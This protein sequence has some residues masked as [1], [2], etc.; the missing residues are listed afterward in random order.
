[1]KKMTRY[2]LMEHLGPFIFAFFT[3]TFLLVIDHVPR[4]IDHVID[5]DISIWIALELVALNLAWMLALSVPMAVLVA[6]LMA[7]GRLTADFEITAIKASG[8]N[9]MRIMMPLLVA[10]SL[11]MVGMVQFNDTILPDLN[12]KARLLW[13]DIAAMRPTLIFRSGIFI[14]DIPGWLVLIDKIDHT[15]SR[16]EGVRITETRDRSKPQI[17]ISEYG[18]MK[19]MDDGLS[20]QFTLYNGEIHKLDTEE[21]ENYRRL[22]FEK[23]VINIA[24]TGTEFKRTDQEYRTDREMNIAQM[25]VNVERAKSTIEPFKE[26][27]KTTLNSKFKYLFSDSF[28]FKGDDTLTAK[29]AYEKVKRE[30]SNQFQA[31]QRSRQQI[32]AQRKMVNKFSVEIYKKYSLPAASLAFILIGAPLGMISRKGGMGMAITISIIMFVIYWAWIIG[33]EDLADRDIISPFWATW[34]ANVV[35]GGIG[36]YLLYKVVSEKPILSFFRRTGKKRN[37]K[38]N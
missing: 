1:M 12:K 25:Q 19:S 23:H 14:S 7:F 36:L 2:I 13:G 37:D 27:I 28:V 35:I 34:G 31:I 22:E 10:G 33:G 9:L 3:I 5:K 6:V 29:V 4:I 11:I 18:F 24:G 8:I 17:V 16:V 32:T 38:K 15:T 26:K 21:P 30:A 20:L